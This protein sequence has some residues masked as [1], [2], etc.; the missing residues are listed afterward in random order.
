MDLSLLSRLNEIRAARGAAILITDLETGSQRLI[1]RGQ[2]YSGDP[3]E[4]ELAKRFRSGKSGTI[5]T[6]AGNHFLTVSVPSPRLVLIGAV[7]ITQALVPMAELAGF[8]VTVI[9]PRTAFATV[10]RFPGTTLHADWPEDVLKNMPLDAYT[11][12]AAVT[13]DPKIDDFP[14]QAALK[15][16]C[17]YVGALGSRKTHGKRLDRL[18]EKGLPETDLA[19]IEAPIGQDIGAASPAEIAVA[20]L[21]SV[22]KALRKPET[23]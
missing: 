11:A 3:L 7:H 15:A 16:E 12:L 1:E 23:D 8:D 5:E 21:G 13:H 6:E 4:T 10:D 22:I 2:V 20:I 19:R 18:R 14:L 17:F 9:D